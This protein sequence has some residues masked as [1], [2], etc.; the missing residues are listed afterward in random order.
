MGGHR[1]QHVRRQAT[2]LPIL[3]LAACATPPG[4]P[5]ES[6]DRAPERGWPGEQ[7]VQV[8]DAGGLFRENLSGLAYQASGS[9]APGVLWAARNGPGS[10]YRLVRDG[11]IWTPDPDNDWG[12]GKR[13]RYPDGSGE[14]D[15]E[16]I[17]FTGSGDRLALYVASE[18]NNQVR[19][20]SRNSVLRFDP[21]APG[22]TLVATHEWDL[23]QD[24]PGTGANA[25][26]EAI[27]FIPDP[28]LVS[29]G[30]RDEGVG[31]VYAPARYPN[32]G[33]GLFFVGVEATGMI[34]GYALNHTDGSFSRIATLSSGLPA[35]M[36]LEF[37]SGS[38]TLWAVC[39]DGCDGRAA[40]LAIGDGAGSG[41][42]GT[43]VV[44]GFIDR[45]TGMPNLNNEGFALAPLAECV[46]GTR[47]V[48]WSD[49]NETD[50]HSLRRG[51][52]ACPR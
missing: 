37:D 3:F 4:Q 40:L 19:D 16:G 46:G 36:A 49:D 51:A 44:T 48:F 47:P 45:P 14:P 7:G 39:D 31:G 5:G 41:R 50:G 2:L 29:G 9:A 43:F 25:G 35:V 38:G 23:T 34:Y 11:S 32:N 10:V 1:I 18:R 30:F 28:F 20:V 15:A 21:G 17:T 8:A 6:W 13:V 42:A 24:I 33:G 22:A 12:D 26:I 27:T 52:L